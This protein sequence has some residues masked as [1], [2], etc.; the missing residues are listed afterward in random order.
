MV[1]KTM[2]KD[3]PPPAPTLGS[4]ARPSSRPAPGRRPQPILP[5]RPPS[6][7]RPIRPPLLLP[8][9]PPVR[10]RRCRDRRFPPP[11]TPPTAPAR[12]S[13]CSSSAAAALTIA[14]CAARSPRSAEISGVAVFGTRASG[15]ARYTRITQ[16][17]NVDRVPALVVVRP[18]GGGTG[19]AEVRYG[20]RSADS[21][22]QAV[23]DVLY[24]GPNVGY[25]PTSR[26]GA[27][28]DGGLSSTP[29]AGPWPGRGDRSRSR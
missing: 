10:F 21:V 14:C 5:L 28:P 29:A 9:A 11:S 2:K 20:F 3:S 4:E 15:I 26:S 7:R 25:R 24:R 8:R 17:V 19:V 12:S 13:P 23:R 16:G 18:Q 22:V 1:M 6:P 27:E